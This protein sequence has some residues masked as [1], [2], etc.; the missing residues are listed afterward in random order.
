MAAVWQV[1]S[2][3]STTG[4]AWR[5]LYKDVGAREERAPCRR[6]GHRFTSRLHVEDLIQVERALGY[7]YELEGSHA[8]HYQWICPP[9]RRAM[10]AIAQ[11]RVWQR[12]RGEPIPAEPATQP[13]ATRRQPMVGYS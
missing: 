10:L 5:Q 11:G 1:L 2:H 9:C 13:P 3:F 12:T 6:C 4:A 7:R 8:E